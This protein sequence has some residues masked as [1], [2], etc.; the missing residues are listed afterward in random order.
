H[1]AEMIP[2][3]VDEVERLV[4]AGGGRPFGRV[5]TDPERLARIEAHHGDDPY[6]LLGE[7]DAG[8]DVVE[9]LLGRLTPAD[10]A[11][12]GEHPTLGVIG[13]E[14]IVEEFLVSH[15]EEHADQLERLARR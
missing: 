3:W 1:C 4:A 13:V 2:Y 5:K 6:R 10:L 11:L 8:V 12:R 14:R 15:L 9:A 7:I